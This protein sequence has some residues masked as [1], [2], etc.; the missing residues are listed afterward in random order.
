MGCK[1]ARY[2]PRIT[3][4][5]ATSQQVAQPHRL[6]YRPVSQLPARQ[7]LGTGRAHAERSLAVDP[8]PVAGL[9]SML[10]PAHGRVVATAGDAVRAQWVAGR[11]KVRFIRGHSRTS[12]VVDAKVKPLARPRCPSTRH[13]FSWRGHKRLVGA[14]RDRPKRSRPGAPL[15]TVV[16]NTSRPPRTLRPALWPLD[17]FPDLGRPRGDP[18]GL[19]PREQD[20]HRLLLG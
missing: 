3:A 2:R 4:Q 12:M 16:G 20:G 10:V 5:R 14:S 17:G 18:C 7:V 19:R 6:A 1:V 9:A 11:H 8:K 15:H 13:A